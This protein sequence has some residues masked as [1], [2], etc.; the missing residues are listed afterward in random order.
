MD[1]FSFYNPTRI[2]FG[3]DKEKLIGQ[4]LAEH[5]VKN[6]L[7]AYGSERIKR[8]GLFA[9]ISQNLTQHGI[10]YVEFGYSQR[11]G[12]VFRQRGNIRLMRC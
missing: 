4:I 6:V 7:L 12:K 3:S 10:R 2:E 1:N 9:T 5:N 11:S 8:D